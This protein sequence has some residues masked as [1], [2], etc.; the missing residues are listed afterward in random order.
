MRVETRQA[1]LDILARSAGPLTT[2]QIKA[3][4]RARSAVSDIYAVLLLLQSAG[5]IT[6]TVSSPWRWSKAAA[7]VA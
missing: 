7:K 2:S 1:V 5:L 4:L 6:C 3:E